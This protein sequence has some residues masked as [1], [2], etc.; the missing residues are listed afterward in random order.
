LRIVRDLLA[1]KPK[2]VGTDLGE[3]LRFVHRIMK[4]R[5]IVV[6]VSDFQA[7]GFERPLGM[8]RRRHDVVAIQLVDPREEQIPHVGLVSLTDPETGTRMVVDTADPVVRRRLQA[9]TVEPMRETFRRTRVD[10]L[11]LSTAEPYERPL[12]GFFKAREKRR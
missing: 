9:S 4:R 8:L 2:G 7:E 10:A 12:A 6:A 1:V 5:G 3:A 11:T